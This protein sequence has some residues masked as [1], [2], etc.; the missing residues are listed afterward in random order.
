MAA[1]T[2]APNRMNGIASIN[3]EEKTS[4]KFWSAGTRDG[5]MTLRATPTS[6]SPAAAAAA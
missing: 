5:S 2:N 6:A 4:K 1:D 3:S